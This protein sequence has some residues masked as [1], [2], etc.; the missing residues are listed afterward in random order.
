MFLIFILF[1][2]PF[3][4][5]ACLFLV[6]ITTLHHGVSL[7]RRLVSSSATFA[8]LSLVGTMVSYREVI[9]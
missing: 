1:P 9:I 6:V 3:I 8:L 5:T 2:L 7:P 4:I